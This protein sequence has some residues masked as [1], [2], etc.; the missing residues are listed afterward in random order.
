MSLQAVLQI[1]MIQ[2]EKSYKQYNALKLLLRQ[3]ICLTTRYLIAYHQKLLN[4]VWSGLNQGRPLESNG[5]E[6]F[7][8]QHQYLKKKILHK[9]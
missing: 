7:V 4:C 6:F 5:Q 3:L 8:H 9:K 1:S 2:N